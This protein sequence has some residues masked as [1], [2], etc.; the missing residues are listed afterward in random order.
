MV[1]M[2]LRVDGCLGAGAANTQTKAPSPEPPTPQ[3]YHPPGASRQPASWRSSWSAALWTYSSSYRSTCCGTSVRFVS[4]WL[5]LRLCAGSLTHTHTR[6]PKNKTLTLSCLAAP[7]PHS[8]SP[9]PQHQTPPNPPHPTPR[10]HAGLLHH[11]QGGALR[12]RHAAR[13]RPSK[14]RPQ[15]GR[16]V[17]AV[18]I[19]VGVGGAVCIRPLG[20]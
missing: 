5:R 12:D 1:S 2:R 9:K 14:H 16:R 6:T 19:W 17:S 7:T 15:E 11:D 8:P 20:S 13:H 3:P 4:T 10:L 18:V